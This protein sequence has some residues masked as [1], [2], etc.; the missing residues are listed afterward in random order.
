MAALTSS[1]DS[2]GKS[3]RNSRVVAPSAKLASTVFRV[4]RVPFRTGSPPTIL[5]VPND[6]VLVVHIQFYSSADRLLTFLRKVGAG[7]CPRGTRR[8]ASC[9]AGDHTGW[10]EH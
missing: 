10:F 9:Y 3:A 4:T 2:V 6:W 7:P 8:L 1:S 5:G